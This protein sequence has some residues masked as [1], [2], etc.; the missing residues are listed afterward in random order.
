MVTL[1]SIFPE[2][3]GPDEEDIRK[4]ITSAT[5]ALDANILLA[6][7]RVSDSQRGQ[8][9]EVLEMVSD[10]LWLPHQAAL[11]YQRNRLKVASDQQK[12]H[13]S[14]AS[15]ATDGFDAAHADYV[16][17]IT[18][19]RN[20]ALKDI[21]DREIRASIEWEFNNVIDSLTKAQSKSR[22]DM[23]S[24]LDKIRIKHTIDFQTV[25]KSDPIRAAI[26]GLITDDRVGIELDEETHTERKKLAAER[27][28]AG[29][30]PG[31][32]D[33]SKDDATGDCL[34]WFELLDLAKNS[35]AYVLYI[36]DGT[37]DAYRKVRGQIVGPH[38][39]LVREMYEYA[40]QGFHQTTLDGF[41]RLARKHLKATVSD[42]TIRTVES[43]RKASARLR[44]YGEISKYVTANS[45][46][47]TRLPGFL[48]DLT[49]QDSNLLNKQIFVMVPIRDWLRNSGVLVH[50]SV[51][52]EKGP[53][54][55]E[56]VGPLVDRRT[57]N[58][59][60][61]IFPD[62]CNNCGSKLILVSRGDREWLECTDEMCHKR[63][64]DHLDLQP[65]S[66][67]QS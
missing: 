7:Y 29:R 41:L 59:R 14:I 34:I 2:W 21:R 27:I 23:R 50:D 4:F 35:G 67:Q 32:A 26:D 66:S 12:I 45:S 22:E 36:T 19:L 15:L 39:Q 20:N 57:G 60:S 58:E 3:Y 40:G 63:L 65:S 61:V 54:G 56:I 18:E 64:S 33:A 46:D 8:I 43:S 31:Y 62:K 42:D 9:L 13:E 28:A 48:I 17:T 25:K 24:A 5:I 10:R 11:E 52:L 1:R 47:G 49:D 55:Y 37:K 44:E 16:Q 6:L 38:V 30:P 53:E 51:I